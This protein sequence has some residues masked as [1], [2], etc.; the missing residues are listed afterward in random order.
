MHIYREKEAQKNLRDSYM[1]LCIV[2]RCMIH[3]YTHIYGDGS[4]GE[5]EVYIHTYM[6]TIHIYD[7]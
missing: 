5:A 4:S 2:Y 3:E 7:L 6:N 1:H